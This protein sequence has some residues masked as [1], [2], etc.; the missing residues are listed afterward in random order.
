V[1]GIEAHGYGL[2]SAAG[3]IAAA[4]AAFASVRAVKRVAE[5]QKELTDRQFHLDLFDK[6]YALVG[7]FI[8]IANEASANGDSWSWNDF[9][10]RLHKL[11][12]LQHRAKFLFGPE[13]P[14]MMTR[15]TDRLIAFK[16]HPD[17]ENQ[18]AVSDQ[19]HELAPVCEPY[20]NIGAHMRLAS[21]FLAEGRRAD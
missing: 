13:V 11:G 5:S 14:E 15:V 8:S 1:V 10:A 3:T 18:K 6:R 12:G 7:D 20:M 4:W 16:R 19:L 9:D 2:L 17:P 21:S